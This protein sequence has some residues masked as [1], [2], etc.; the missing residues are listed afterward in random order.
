MVISQRKG[1]G[2][3]ITGCCL[4]DDRF[5]VK[6]LSYFTFSRIQTPIGDSLSLL[7]YALRQISPSHL[8]PLPLSFSLSSFSLLSRVDP[9]LPI[10]PPLSRFVL[11]LFSVLSFLTNVGL[12]R[13]PSLIEY[14]LC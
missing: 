13:S 8:Y 14:T 3:S 4:F 10:L 7:I 6:A 1:D 9:R 5:V 2:T 11:S 12:C